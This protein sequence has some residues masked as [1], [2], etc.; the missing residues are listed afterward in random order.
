MA[1]VGWRRCFGV[2][3]SFVVFFGLGLLAS[4]SLNLE[5]LSEMK[6][7]LEILSEPVVLGQSKSDE[8]V[9]VSSKYKQKY[10]C[11]LPALAVKFH[12]D[13]DE[14]SRAYSGMG[15]SDLIRPMEAAPCLLKTKDW[16]TY[17][18]CYGKYVQQYH[19]EE[20]E[21]KG[22]ILYLGYYQSEF[23]WNN[24]TAK[25]SKHHRL[26]RYHS[27][28][29]INGS[30]CDLNGHSRETE[31]R[32]MCEEGSGDYIARV[33]E[34]QSCSYVLTVHTTRI[35]HHPFLRLPST[36]TPQSIKCHPALSP[37]QYVAYVKAQ[38]SDTKRIVEEI[39]EE[40][41]TLDTKMRG[42]QEA[43]SARQNLETT[44][45]EHEVEE[46]SEEIAEEA[47]MVPEEESVAKNLEDDE[48]DFWDK[49]LQP[50]AQ[51]EQ[52]S[53]TEAWEEDHVVKAAAQQTD[54]LRSKLH[55]K[56]IRNPDDLVNFIKELKKSAEKKEKGDVA[57]ENL[58]N[59]PEMTN[60]R[61]TPL[62]KK[63]PQEDDKADDDEIIIKEFEKELEEI[64]LPKSEI[65]KLKEDVK[66]EMEKEF[67]V[68][69]DEAQEELE[70]EGLKGE[71]DRS[72][73]SKSLASTLNK[74]I[75]KIDDK[76]NE[77][78]EEMDADDNT[79]R[80][81]PSPLGKPS[82]GKIEIKIVTTGGFGDEDDTHWLSDEDTKNLKEIFFNILV[83]GTEEV[84]REQ[85][86]QQQLEH[87]YRFIWDQ[88]REETGT[89][90]GTD[91]DEMDF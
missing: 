20:S 50:E 52:T 65:S 47:H 77:K 74:L 21:V 78:G 76:E 83:Q 17:E 67:D 71:F 13:R 25:A 70:M 37:E 82:A 28:M 12:Q 34:P 61:E 73:A 51:D 79:S 29:Y 48:T 63:Q 3:W 16:W 38:V 87:N 55:F 4:A 84:H 7:G 26:K 91:S 36:A 57:H 1:A 45:E 6:Y 85:K 14:D 80:G 75:D 2:C 15:I 42:T 5:E 35:C 9:M 72:Q 43:E 86:R 59:D 90:G 40:L 24:E 10:E 39:S 31:V 11:K 64:L 60:T 49:V 81:S 58:E 46:G 18:F 41:K 62:K 27:Q 8:V 54:G 68:I 32:F 23:D 33:D 30:R 19:V 22:D 53:D 56:V 66:T 88:N 89:A 44:K 69:I